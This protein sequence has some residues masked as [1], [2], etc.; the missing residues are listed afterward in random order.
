MVGQHPGHVGQQPAAV[1]RL[2][3]DG[4]EEEAARGRGPLDVDQPLRLLGEGLRVGA[5][6][7]YTSRC[8]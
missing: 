7:L 5:C 4:D 2:H 8:V 3:L 6:L 1:Q